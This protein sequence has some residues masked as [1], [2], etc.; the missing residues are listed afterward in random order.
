LGYIYES[1]AGQVEVVE[2]GAFAVTSL[3]YGTSIIVL[4]VLAQ[5][6]YR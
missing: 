1:A 6:V 2:P 5:K 3:I 4:F